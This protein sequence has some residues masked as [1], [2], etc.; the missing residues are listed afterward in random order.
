MQLKSFD[1]LHLDTR[2]TA[3]L[4]IRMARADA[5]RPA[6]PCGDRWIGMDNR[7]WEVFSVEGDYATAS[8][9]GGRRPGCSGSGALLSKY[10]IS[11]CPATRNHRKNRHYSTHG[12]E[13]Y[14]PNDGA[15]SLPEGRIIDVA[16]S[17][18]EGLK[19]NG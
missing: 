1:L 16:E 3:A 8:T 7:R 10:S 12:A 5:H 6:R 13:S 4:T 11:I 2:M 17:L 14:V 19:E 9:G 18:K 15:D